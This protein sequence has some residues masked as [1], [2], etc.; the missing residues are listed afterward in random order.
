MHTHTQDL[1][2]EVL[3][4]LHTYYVT[5][6][7]QQSSLTFDPSDLTSQLAAKQE[8]LFQALVHFHIIELATYENALEEAERM[9][10][11]EG[12]RGAGV[13]SNYVEQQKR[14]MN[15]KVGNK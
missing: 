14:M 6:Q 3:E 5:A 12:G 1:I 4:K 7:Q 15:L 10:E 8:Q 11:E 9:R 2:Q 13:G